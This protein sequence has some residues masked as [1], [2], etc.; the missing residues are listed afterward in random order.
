VPADIAHVNGT[1]AVSLGVLSSRGGATPSFTPGTLTCATYCHGATLG[2]GTNPTPTW[3]GGASQSA[4]GTCHG[5]PPPAPHTTSTACGSCHPGYTSSTVNATTHLDGTVQATGGHAAGFSAR[6][7]HG[8]QASR[9]GLSGCKGCHGNDLAGG[10]GTSCNGCHPGATSTAWQTDCTFCHGTPG[11]LASPPVDTQGSSDTS[12]VSVGAHA[13]HLALTLMTA[14]SVT[15]ETCHP[16]RG[17]VVTDT[18]HMD[19]GTAEVAFTGL[20]AQGT[21][22]TFTRTGDTAATC[23]TYCHGRYTGNNV[24]PSPSWVGTAMGCTSCH[25]ATGSALTRNHT[26]SNHRI[27][28]SVCHGDAYTASGS[29]STWTGT[30]VGAATHVDGIRTIFI[31]SSGTGIRSWNASTRTCTASCH[32]SKT[33]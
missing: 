33:W 23:A 11:G 29:G 27:A 26:R 24:T 22:S 32:G 7:Q 1:A 28:C 25:A 8:Y 30:G 20:A 19:G 2:G 13:K 21:A 9:D 6:E 18:G 3:T 17:N 5:L 4:C 15:C 31:R 16:T 12:Q 10:T 14:S